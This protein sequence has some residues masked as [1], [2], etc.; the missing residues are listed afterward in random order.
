MSDE[1]VKELKETLNEIKRL[2]ND[3][4]RK[5]HDLTVAITGDDSKGLEGVVQRQKS[6][7]QRIKIIEWLGSGVLIFLIISNE[8]FRT[9]FVTLLK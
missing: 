3:Q 6:Q 9:L 2:Q 7:G 4:G 8:M 1:E 5:L